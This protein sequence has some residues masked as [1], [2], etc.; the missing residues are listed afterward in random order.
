MPE[1]TKASLDELLVY[2][3]SK[4]IESGE[5]CTFE[6]LVCECFTL[7]PAAFS[8][9]RYPE[10]PDSARVNKAWLRARTDKGWLV[11]SVQEGF[12]LTQTGARVSERV[13]K[14]IGSGAMAASQES[15]G[16]ARERFESLIRAIRRD[17]LFRSFQEDGAKFS[18]T[19]M[20]FRRLLGATLETPARILRQNLNAYVNAAAVYD[21]KEAVEF[22]RDCE[23]K[24]APTLGIVRENTNG[25]E[26]AD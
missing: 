12:S 19:E 7:F 24:M 10:W 4:V 17:P 2:A 1:R 18:V 5:E 15:S 8:L 11:G 14:Q 26:R 22:L 6:R 13:A 16:R 3:A 25:G 9:R 23:N 20:D 21:D